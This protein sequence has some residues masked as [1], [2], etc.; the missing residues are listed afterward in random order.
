MNIDEIRGAVARG[1]CTPENE[2]KV[3]DVDL[4]FAISKEIEKLYKEIE[5]GRK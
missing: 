3:M 5:N 2:N 1:W 4:A